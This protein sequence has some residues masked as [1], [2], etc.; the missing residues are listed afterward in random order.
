MRRFARRLGRG[1]QN[2]LE[3]MRVGRL[4]APYQAPHEVLLEQGILKLRRYGFEPDEDKDVPRPARV[5]QA[6]ILVPPLM[7]TAEVYDISPELSA[8]SWLEAQGLDVWVV[9]FGA[10]EDVEG[11]MERSLDDHILA[12]DRAVTYVAQATGHPVH[13]GGYSQGG[14]FAYLVAAYRRNADL[15]SVITFGSPVDMRQNLPIPVED[16]LAA[17]IL[18]QASDAISGVVDRIEGLPGTFSAGGFKLLS[19][20]K[21]IQQI[22]KTIGLLHDRE[23]LEKR[24][25]QRRFLGGDGFI[26]FPGPALRDLVYDI[27][28]SNRL[29]TGGVVINGRSVGLGDITVPI[30]YFVGTSDSIARP[31]SVRAIREVASSQRIE[32]I[33]VP[34]GHFGIVV[35]SR[36]MAETWPAVSEWVAWHAGTGPEPRRFKAGAKADPEPQKPEERGD[37]GP[38]GVLYDLATDMVDGLWGRVSGV[39]RDVV[40]VVDAMRWQLPRL[41]KLASLEDRSRIS[42][43]RALA[44]QAAA[45]PDAPFLLWQGRAFTYREADEVVNRLAHALL[46][47]GLR[48]G[49]HVAIL[50]GNH[51]ETLSLVAALS[52]IGV[53][54]ALLPSEARGASLEQALAVA[55]PAALVCGVEHLEVGLEAHRRAGAAGPVLVLGTA[56]TGHASPAGVVSIDARIDP[57]AVEPPPEANPGRAADLAMLMY[58]S[59]T[60]GLPKAARITNRRW[61]LAALGSAAMCALTPRD[62]VYVCLPLHHATAMLVGAGGALVGGARLA[63]SPRFSPS[64][65]WTDVRRTGATV[66]F[67]VGELGRYLVS[68]PAPREGGAERQ[69]P[70]RLFVGVGMRADVWQRLRERFG[71]VQVLEFYGSTEGNVVL[72][73]LT[74]EKIGSVGRPLLAQY[75]GFAGSSDVTAQVSIVR[76]DDRNDRPLRAHNGLCERCLDDEPGLLVARIRE[77]H[78]MGHFDG[79]TDA[80]ATERKILRDVFELGDAW[81]DTGDLLRRDADGDYWFVDRV[82]D[83]FRWKGE[84]MSTEQVAAVVA[85]ASFVQMAT[86]YG[87]ALPGHEGKAGMAAVEVRSGHA[88]DGAELYALCEANLSSAARPRFVRVVDRLETT[89]TLK[90]KKTRLEADGADPARVHDAVF[91]YDEAGRTYAALDEEAYRRALE[92]L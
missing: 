57:D 43:G 51:P 14:M 75:G 46:G 81:F 30:L 80:A 47:L 85:R 11:G 84:N 39:S 74:G 38:V 53:V 71:A 78:P 33:G 29:T 52:R 17:R 25:A 56:R 37:A 91:V 4:S 28:A 49:E 7:V 55:S 60:T 50:A 40:G 63:L 31:G 54:A 73:N 68:M 58:T 90:F 79:Y 34:A 2:A 15:A 21:E 48:R 10:P 69:H 35:G 16:G 26:A 19:P 62:T 89:E 41:A 3:L 86:V 66:V 9:D 88:F 32:E 67:Y 82:G 44:E 61:A 70:I 24:E 6:I 22:L 36:A 64:T 27:V 92:R 18:A 87:V 76:W 23:A 8:V 59:G 77:S 83:T 12:I 72:A 45:I 5:P 42:I 1:A 20:R 65:F 13:L